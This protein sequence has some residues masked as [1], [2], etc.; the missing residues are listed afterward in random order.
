MNNPVQ[1]SLRHGWPAATYWKKPDDFDRRAPIAMDETI[2]GRI[3]A[4]SQEVTG[5]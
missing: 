4:G 1:A 5:V 3:M 2:T